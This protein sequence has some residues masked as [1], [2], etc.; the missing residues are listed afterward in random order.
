[1][2]QSMGSQRVR[3]NL[4]T[5]QQKPQ[6]NYIIFIKYIIQCH[7]GERDVRSI[8]S[9]SLSLRSPREVKTSVETT[10][11]QARMLSTF[12]GSMATQEF[13]FG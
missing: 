6:F 8:V 13:G 12:R 10:L 7:K 9:I 3:H 5:E 1:M 11:T 4:V 2:M